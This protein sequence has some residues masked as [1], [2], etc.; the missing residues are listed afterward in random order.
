MKDEQVLL[1]I[2]FVVAAITITGIVQATEL[3]K[4]N[5]CIKA[6]HTYSQ[7]QCH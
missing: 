3:V 5:T 2:I 7:G 6:G 4:F 1:V